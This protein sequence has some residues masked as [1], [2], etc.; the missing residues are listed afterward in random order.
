MPASTPAASPLLSD[1]PVEIGSQ[2]CCWGRF[3]RPLGDN[4]G[5]RSTSD[6]HHLAVR[7][8]TTQCFLLQSLRISLIFR[9]DDAHSPTR[10]HQ[11]TEPL[12]SFFAATAAVGLSV[13][14]RLPVL[15]KPV[16]VNVALTNLPILCVAMH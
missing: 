4:R 5:R 10:T 16:P 2:S 6:G 1:V 12:Q 14:Y 11:A 15:L 9:F 13:S 7:G 3:G 8:P